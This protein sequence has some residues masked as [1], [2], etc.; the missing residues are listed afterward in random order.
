MPQ[1]S[2]IGPLGQHLARW[3]PNRDLTPLVEIN[4]H[5]EDTTR[6]LRAEVRENWE[7]S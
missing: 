2:E 7:A 5:N 3:R 1:A 6:E 4:L